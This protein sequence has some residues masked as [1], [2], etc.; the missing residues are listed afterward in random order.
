[1]FTCCFDIHG[2]A[3]THVE[4]VV[5]LNKIKK[6]N[7]MKNKVLTQKLT[8]N[9]RKIAAKLLKKLRLASVEVKGEK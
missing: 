6:Q 4:T 8:N 2:I 9:E 3:S 1:M 5:L 7:Y